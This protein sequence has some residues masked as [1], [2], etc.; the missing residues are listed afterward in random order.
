[1][2]KQLIRITENDLHDMVMEAV[3]KVIKEDMDIPD[4][5]PVDKEPVEYPDDEDDEF[6]QDYLQDPDAYKDDFLSDLG[7]GD[8][9]R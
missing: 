1:M 8:L 6:Y 3:R 5:G 9:Y 7:D 2:K 4:F